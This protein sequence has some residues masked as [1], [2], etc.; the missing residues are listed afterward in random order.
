MKDDEGAKGNGAGLLLYYDRIH[1]GRK[2]EFG[3][4]LQK[5]RVLIGWMLSGP[6]TTKLLHTSHHQVA[7]H[8]G[9]GEWLILG[10][11]I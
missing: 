9:G 7:P 6:C 10:H 4:L 5:A 8:T 11:L 2:M 3:Q 1:L